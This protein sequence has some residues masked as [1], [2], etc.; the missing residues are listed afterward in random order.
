MT[1]VYLAKGIVNLPLW[2]NKIMAKYHL[3]ALNTV[4]F[5]NFDPE[6]FMS[7]LDLPNNKQQT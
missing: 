3:K 6:S 5:F 1:V 4:T 7:T 2:S